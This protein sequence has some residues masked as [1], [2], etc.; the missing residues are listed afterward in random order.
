ML[1]SVWL[2]GTGGFELLVTK[3]SV[4]VMNFAEIWCSYVWNLILDIF[5]FKLFVKCVF[6][7]S[8]WLLRM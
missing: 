6:S 3:R 1:L 7:R 8:V 4:E 5:L 2:L